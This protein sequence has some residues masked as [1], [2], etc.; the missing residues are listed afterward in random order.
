[1]ATNHHRKVLSSIV[2][3]LARPKYAL[4]ALVTA[5]VVLGLLIWLFAFDTLLYVV[6]L[7][8]YPVGEKVQLLLSGYT[9]SFRYIDDPVIFTRVIFSGLAGIAAALYW[10]VRTHTPKARNRKGLSG[11]VVALFASG[12]VACG[13]SILSPLLVGVGAAASA[14]LGIVIGIVGNGIGI[15]LMAY[16]IRGLA[17]QADLS[18][19]QEYEQE[20]H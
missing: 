9:N 7:P 17:I 8:D 18:R 14:S 16:A 4:I 11:F 19:V 5:F 15:I 10:F 12:C 3:V 6:A 1:M 20:H 2:A 13:T